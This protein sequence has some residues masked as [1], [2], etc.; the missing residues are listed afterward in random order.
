MKSIS[1]DVEVLFEIKAK[2]TVNKKDVIDL[3]R[4]FIHVCM[5]GIS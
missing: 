5:N 4:W 3:P 2:S 1:V